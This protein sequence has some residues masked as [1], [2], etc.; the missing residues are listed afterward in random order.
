MNALAEISGQ[1]YKT[2]CLPKT[3]IWRGAQRCSIILQRDFLLFCKVSAARSNGLAS[4][5]GKLELI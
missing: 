1:P 2:S 4:R 3:L 5:G